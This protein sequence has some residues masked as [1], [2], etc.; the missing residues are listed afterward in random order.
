MTPQ[1]IAAP[2]EIAERKRW[3][4]VAEKGSSLGIRFL[5]WLATVAGRGPARLVVRL[6]AGWYTLLHPTVRAASKAWWRRILGREPTL[7]EIYRHVLR[8]AQTT[9]DRC[10]FLQGRGDVFQV[11][12]TG[13]DFLADLRARNQGA[14]ILTAHVGSPAAMSVEG[15]ALKL[16]MHI[17]GYFKNAA[18]IN[19]VMQKLDPASMARVVHIEPGNVN[20]VFAIR[21]RIE[22]GDLLAIACDRV[23]IN[24]R[25]VEVDF[26]GEKAA[27]PTGPFILAGMLHCPVYIA[28]ALY[29][30]PDRYDLYCEPFADPLDLPRKDREAALQR[31]VARYAAR[32]EHYCRLAPDNWFNF[33]DF[34][35]KH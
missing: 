12:H 1:A 6:V 7:G 35:S 24:D 31:H 21:E 25:F 19:D 2:D 17:V 34:W 20:S 26:F 10:F 8:F 23:G 27:F 29:H 18:M 11:T 22:A 16:R 15:R 32:M 4:H 14:I 3:M 9:L 5:I 33:F 30:E 28:Y 13:A